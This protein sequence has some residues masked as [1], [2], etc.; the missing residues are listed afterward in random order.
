MKESVPRVPVAQVGVGCREQ[1]DAC[2]VA[3]DPQSLLGCKKRKQPG[4][5]K[6]QA[7]AKENWRLPSEGFS[8]P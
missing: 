5:G 1:P 2:S 3:S 8:G 4:S 6:G 7:G